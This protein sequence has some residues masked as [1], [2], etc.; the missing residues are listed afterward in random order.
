MLAKSAPSLFMPANPEVDDV[1]KPED[2]LPVVDETDTVKAADLT[3][4]V[5]AGKF[6]SVIRVED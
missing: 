2:L 6:H 1:Y 4:D 3:V 5:P